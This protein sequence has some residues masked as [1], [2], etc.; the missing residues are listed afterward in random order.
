MTVTISSDA[1]PGNEKVRLL[2]SYL[3]GPGTQQGSFRNRFDAFFES[4]T[5]LKSLLVS[6]SIFIVLFFE[7]FFMT[8]FYLNLNLNF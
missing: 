7:I 5:A 3:E 4:K 1:T 2:S 8:R 6:N